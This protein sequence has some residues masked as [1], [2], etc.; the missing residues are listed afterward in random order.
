MFKEASLEIVRH[1]DVQHS[2]A[3]REDVNKELPRHV[4]FLVAESRSLAA[5]GMTPC[6]PFGMTALSTARDDSQRILITSST[7]PAFPVERSS[8]IVRGD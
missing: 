5:L 4:Q 7:G 6:N 3:A 8:T 1:A 2:P